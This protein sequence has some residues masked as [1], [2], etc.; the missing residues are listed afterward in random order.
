MKEN[1]KPALL[2]VCL[3]NICR[4]P[5]AQA[6]FRAKAQ[7]MNIAVTIDSAGTSDIHHGEKPDARAVAAGEQRGYSFSGIRSRG[8]R[9]ADFDTF[10]MIL[11]ADKNNLLDLLAICPK[12]QQH[13]VSMLLSHTTG[14]EQEIPDPYY[15]GKQGFEQVLD[16]LEAAAEDILPRL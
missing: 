16:L 6:V 11:A 9:L 15:G 7:Q 3:G 2:I 10:D 8:I 13:K 12:H 1:H 5:T 4:S 14:P